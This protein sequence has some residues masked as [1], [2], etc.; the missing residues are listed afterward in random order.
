MRRGRRAFSRGA[1]LVA[2]AV[3][4]AAA[5]GAR[6][7]D[8]TVAAKP[9]EDLKAVFGT[10]E[11]V[12]TAPARARIG[13]TIR[14][15]ALVEG[16]RVAA[17]QK[18][19]RVVDPKL[20]LQS[21]ALEAKIKSLEAQR[22]LAETE[23]KRAQELRA[24]GTGTQVRLDTAQ[25]N[26]DAL[27]GSVAAAV[28]ERAVVEE[29]LKEG[30]VVAP[31]NGRV[32]K[33][34]SVNGTV[35]MAGETIFDIATETYVLRIT[36]PERHARFMREGGRVMV[37]E[38]GLAENQKLREG[39]IRQV[40]PE[41]QNGRVVADV[42]VAGLG[43]YF[44][45]ERTRVYVG[46]GTRD[47]ILIPPD[48]VIRRHGLAFVRLKTGGEIVVQPGTLQNGGLEILSGLRSGDII[49]HP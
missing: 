44:V 28:A 25:S 31:V 9:I 7:Q 11:S 1:G 17:G 35:V 4:L 8:L 10:V 15:I 23:L 46:A 18:L 6:A 12:R 48:Y 24:T 5:Q 43:D 34:K 2:G 19:A 39:R 40:Y 26:L 14:D 38:R 22:G 41:M 37:G 21:A 30:D 47:A 27:R 32:L 33:V 20:T 3:L 45:G 42:E 16:A 29:Q 49:V 36:V 13:G